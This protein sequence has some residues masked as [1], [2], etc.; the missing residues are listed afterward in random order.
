MEWSR[1]AQICVIVGLVFVA[2]VGFLTGLW[3][4]PLPDDLGQYSD[5]GV[6]LLFLSKLVFGIEMAAIFTAVVGGLLLALFAIDWLVDKTRVTP[7]PPP[8]RE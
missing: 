8:D 7:P 1:R 3:S 5:E 4:M 2:S 6:M